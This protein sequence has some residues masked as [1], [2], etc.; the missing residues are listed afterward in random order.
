M[1]HVNLK[2]CANFLKLVGKS[3]LETFQVNFHKERSRGIRNLESEVIPVFFIF[4]IGR[5]GTQFFSRLLNNDPGAIVVHEP[6]RRDFLEYGRSFNENYSYDKYV[7][8]RLKH[9]QSVIS[10]K[11]IKV[12]GEV[13]SALRRHASTIMTNIPNVKG[14]FLIRDGRAVVRS[15]MSRGAMSSSAWYYNKVT[16]RPGDPYFSTWGTMNTFEKCCWVWASENALLYKHFG[17][18][19]KF[20]ILLKDYQYIKS[21]LFDVIHLNISKAEWD[22][23]RVIKSENRTKKHTYDQYENWSTECKDTFWKIC[24]DMMQK[25]DYRRV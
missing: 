14:L 19:M 22:K 7:N 11:K 12:Y 25:H 5:S 21:N 4:S 3:S 10:N 1:N 17:A 6:L 13:N 2:Y 8:F 18:A 24:G 15:M 16:P 9:I 20:E 23:E